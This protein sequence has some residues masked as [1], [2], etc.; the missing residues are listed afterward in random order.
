MSPKINVVNFQVRLAEKYRLV[1]F[2]QNMAAVL[3]N[4]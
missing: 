4:K 1:N 3:G 2:T